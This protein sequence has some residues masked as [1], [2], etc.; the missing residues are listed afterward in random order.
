M[1]RN[2]ITK[3][4]IILAGSGGGGVKSAGEALASAA[5]LRYKYVTCVPFYSIAKRGGL[6]ESTIIFSDEEIASPL[7]SQAQTVVLLD[8]SVLKSME[9]RVIPGGLLL[10]ERDSLK[11]S[12]QRKDI[13]V[14][15][16]P[17][18]ETAFK[19]GFSLGASF[20]LIGAYVAASKALA[21]E[22]IEREI[23]RRFAAKEKVIPL[24]KE[25]FREGMKLIATS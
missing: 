18:V 2:D 21:P 17:A 22:L 15:I 9:D 13:R 23:E 14:V 10:L 6:S 3:G 5:S 16:V 8:S 11:E 25:A 19:L 20:V 7:L 1:K 12:V 4:E 24:N